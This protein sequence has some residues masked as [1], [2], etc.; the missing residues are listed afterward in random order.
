M[1]SEVMYIRSSSNNPANVAR[2]DVFSFSFLRPP[3]LKL[4][5]K[6]LFHVVFASTIFLSTAEHAA[7]L[8]R[9]R[10]ALHL[11]RHLDVN[12]EELAHAAVQ[13]HGLALVEVGFAVLWGNALLGAGVDEPAKVKVWLEMKGA[14]L[15][16]VSEIGVW[17]ARLGSVFTMRSRWFEGG[18]VRIYW[19]NMPETISISAS[20]AAIFSA[21]EGWGRPPPK[22][23][24]IFA[25][26]VGVLFG[27]VE[28]L[29][30]ALRKL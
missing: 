14:R 23:K 3:F 5:L 9:G 26:C 6:S 20:A 13:A 27:C 1:Q 19:L 7:A 11:L 12:L 28:V 22:R 30:V 24:D 2:Q 16:R 25:G 10:L 8:L 15:Q 17:R 4:L 29:L 18:E 21:E